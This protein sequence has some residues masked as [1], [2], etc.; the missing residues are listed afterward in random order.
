MNSLNPSITRWQGMGLMATTLLGTGVFILPQLTIQTAGHLAGLTWLLLTLAILPLAL[1]F[2]QLGRQFPSAAGP[3]FF[4]QAAFGR[5]YGYVIGLMFL[6]VVPLGAPAALIM[7]FE[8]LK[9]IMPLTPL[10]ATLGQLATLGLLFAFNWRGLNLSGR[11]Q[12]AL[13]LA[14]VGV[15]VALVSA[16][17]WQAPAP[18]TPMLQGSTAGMLQALGLALWSFLGVEAL[19]HLSAEFRDPQ[20][21][22]V[23]AVVG[24]TLLVGVVYSACT[25]LSS[26][27]STAPLAIVGAYTLLLGD[28]ARWVIAVLGVASGLATVNVYLAS[29]SRLAWSLSQEGILPSYMQVLNQHRVPSNALFV[30]L[31]ACSI[32]LVVAHVAGQQFEAMV[33]WTNGVFVF[34]YTASMLAAWRLLAKRY[35][36]AIGLSLLVCLGFALSLGSALLYGLCLALMV[37][38]WLNLQALPKAVQS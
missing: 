5:R 14:I 34:I 25:W 11:A 17:L 33:R 36:L 20:R 15:I 22:F 18:K 26:L 28:S 16:Y 12:L 24:G 29:V 37:G 3:A 27:D 9:P 35:R 1:V 13:T 38:F 8:F 2:A 30:V 32:T 31:L 19:T 4:V 6:L 23:P 10:Q 7:T 21:D